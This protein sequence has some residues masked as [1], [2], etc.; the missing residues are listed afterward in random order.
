MERPAERRPP[1][2]RH[3]LRPRLA[4]PVQPGLPCAVAAPAHEPGRRRQQCPPGRRRPPP[5]RRPG[6]GRAQPQAPRLSAP[7]P[8]L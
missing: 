7:R 4:S 3:R 6:G 2:A 8:A 1:S 5:P